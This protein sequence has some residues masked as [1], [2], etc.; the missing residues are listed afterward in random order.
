[1]KRSFSKTLA[2]MGKGLQD[3]DD[4]CHFPFCLEIVEQDSIE[5]LGKTFYSNN[6]QFFKNITSDEVVT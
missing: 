6:R 4:L 5:Y 3:E 1:L 2:T